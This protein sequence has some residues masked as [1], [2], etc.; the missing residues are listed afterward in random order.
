MEKSLRKIVPFLAAYLVVVILG[1][2]LL[3][4]VSLIPQ[5]WL[6]DNWKADRNTDISIQTFHLLEEDNYA[7]LVDDYTDNMKTDIAYRLNEQSIFL[8]SAYV[9]SYDMTYEYGRYWHGYCILL[10]PLLLVLN[11]NQIRLLYG[12][13][14]LC[15]FLS[16]IAILC[17]KKHFQELFTLICAAYLC[18][19]YVT[20]KSLQY[21]NCT[22]AALLASCLMLQKQSLYRKRKGL[23]FFIIGML[24]NFFD[25]LTFESLTLSLPLLFAESENEERL[26][27][28]LLNVLKCSLL[29]LAG[30]ALMFA[31]KCLLYYFAAPNTAAYMLGFKITQRM[32]GVDSSEKYPFSETL[33]LT[34]SCLKGVTFSNYGRGFWFS[35][36]LFLIVVVLRI[37]CR[38]KRLDNAITAFVI[39]LIP[40]ARFFVV[41]EHSSSHFYFTYYALITSVIAVFYGSASIVIELYHGFGFGSHSDSSRS[42]R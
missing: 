37:F 25:L 12:A 4:L 36:I 32:F 19:F 38:N 20:T 2:C 6:T 13:V 3:F 34:L 5:K 39:G 26:S 29:W 10:R 21:F 17:R 28:K 33:K 23:C 8:P 27:R 15:A 16:L 9:E 30:Y 24:V 31:S 35:I 22:F 42:V 40:I 11:R 41:R 14:L 7:T 18:N 1:I